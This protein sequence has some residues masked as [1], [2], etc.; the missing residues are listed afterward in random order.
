[1]AA[2]VAGAVAGGRADMLER[3][4]SWV[5]LSCFE[6]ITASAAEIIPTWLID[7]V[8]IKFYNMRH[9]SVHGDENRWSRRCK[10]STGTFSIWNLFTEPPIA[11]HH[12]GRVVHDAP[13]R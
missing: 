12:A 1:M 10:L 7:A 4:P 6:F 3:T 2:V 13:A 8:V 11:I 9:H 5:H